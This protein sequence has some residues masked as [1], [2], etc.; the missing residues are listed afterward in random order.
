ML[1]KRTLGAS[2]IDVSIVGLGGNTFGP[3]RLDQQETI[4]VIDAA[5]GQGVNFVDTANVYGQGRSEEFLGVALKGRRDQMVIATKFNLVKPSD[6]P[7]RK[8]IMDQ[9]DESLKKLQTD[10]VDLYQIHMPTA[11]LDTD[12]LHAVLDD[13]VLSGKARSIGACNYAAWRLER[14]QNVAVSTGAARFAT[15]QNYY[16]LLARDIES[17]IS[18]WCR[19]NSTSV[20]PYFPLAGGFLTGKYRAGEPPPPNSRGANGSGIVDYIWTPENQATLAKLEAFC[21]AR[22]RPIAQ[23]AIAWLLVSQSVTSV[24][25]GVSNPQQ[26]AMNIGA[27]TWTL[28]ADEK[29][30]VDQIVSALSIANPEKPPHESRTL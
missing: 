23:L 3:P 10:Y 12:E 22:D 19:D 25:S 9:L 24:I 8:R 1:E 21:E 5:L 7:P 11:D 18:P 13:I 14:S 26:L 30:E 15:V 29:A 20:L 4:N 28:T 16:N 17:E 6:D 2:G 27:A